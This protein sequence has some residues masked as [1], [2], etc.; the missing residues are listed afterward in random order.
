MKKSHFVKNLEEGKI[1][2]TI[3]LVVEK[4]IK[5]KKDGKGDYLYLVLRDRTGKISAFMWDNFE[6]I[7]KDIKPGTLIKIKGSVQ[8]YKEKLQIVLQN[9]EIYSEE[10]RLKDFLPSTDKDIEVLYQKVLEKIDSLNNEKLKNLLKNIYTSPEYKPLILQVPAAK[11]Y[12]H[13]CIGGLLEHTVSLL[14]L[15]ELILQHYKDLNKDLLLSGI[16][17]H[18][19]GKI[20]ELDT[21]SFFEYTKAGR[22]VGHITMGVQLLEREAGKIDN[23]PPELKDLL[24]H[25]IISHHGQL[26]YGSPKQPMIKEAFALHFIDLIDSELKGFDEIMERENLDFSYSQQLER[27]I[28][29][30]E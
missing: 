8:S 11:G 29:K 26:E 16:L 30:T 6:K 24:T 5:Q 19:I 13:A 3:F 15:A 25:M 23:F 1:I 18:D 12:H 20:W 17:L 28:F 2:E 14:E 10:A 27:F 7:H 9:L 4:E 21:K 22:M